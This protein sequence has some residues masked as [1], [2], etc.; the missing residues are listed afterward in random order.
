METVKEIAAE[1]RNELKKEFPACKF[2]VRSD[3]ISMDVSLMSAPFNP[4][5]DEAERDYYQQINHYYVSESR[6]LTEEGKELL[7]KVCKIA[8]RKNWDHSDCQV[9][10]FDVNYY[11]HL[12]VGKWDKPFQVK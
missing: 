8:N 2:S 9:D 11:F 6:F 10:Y 12:E 5:T 3:A 1:V 7:Q 4:L